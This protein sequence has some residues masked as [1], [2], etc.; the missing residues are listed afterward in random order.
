MRE[1]KSEDMNKDE[2]KWERIL[3]W[4]REKVISVR[5]RTNKL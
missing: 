2:R 1:S 4:E 3:E 5:S